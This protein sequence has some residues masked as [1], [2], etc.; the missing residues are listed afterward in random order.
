[1]LPVTDVI[2]VIA[3]HGY[4]ALFLAVLA[5]AI[6]LPLPAAIALITAGAATAAHTLQLPGVVAAA[7]LAMLLGD[8]LM[9][10]LGREMGWGLLGFLCKVSIN[11]ETCILRSA[12]SFYR[13]GRVTLLIA[14]FIPGVNA[15]APPLAGSMKMRYGQFLWLDAAGALL[16]ALSYAI[17]GFVFR[18][19]LASI[20]H[21]FHAAGHVVGYILISAIAIYFGYR[22]WLYWQNRIFRVV[23]RVQV[24]EL[25]RLLASDD[26]IKV[27]VVDVRSHGYYDGNAERIRGSIRIEPNHLS[28]ELKGLPKD[29]DIYV[30]CT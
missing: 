19:F 2:A 1:L 23:P 6:N 9:F 4:L 5:E 10:V 26:A 7:V 13:R 22:L 8:S 27:Q 14:K 15:M 11:P 18:D 29:K 28:E 30:Y 16:Y 17:L 3:H 20:T 25:A 24:Q 12:E 21:S